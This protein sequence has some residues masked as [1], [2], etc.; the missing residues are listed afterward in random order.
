MNK[1]LKHYA[2]IELKHIQL[3]LQNG[4]AQHLRHFVDQY[5]CYTHGYVSKNNKAAWGKIVGKEYLSE[6]AKKIIQDKNYDKSLI[7]QKEHIVPLNFISQK[8]QQIQEINLINIQQCLDEWLLFATI[9]KEEDKRLN[10]FKSEM[11]KEFFEPSSSLFQDKFA[12]YK[13][14]HTNIPLFR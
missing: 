7:V 6:D 14:P 10:I 3:E 1:I 12:R 11:P 5:F 13:H 9:T 4:R 2:Q 8:L